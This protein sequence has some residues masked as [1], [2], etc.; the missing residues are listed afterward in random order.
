MPP[1]SKKDIDL[2]L[3][4]LHDEEVESVVL[5]ANKRILSPGRF[6]DTE[7]GDGSIKAAVRLVEHRDL[8]IRTQFFVAFGKSW[9]KLVRAAILDIKKREQRVATQRA[10]A[11]AKAKAKAK[12]QPAP[13]AQA[14]AIASP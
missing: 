11:R 2:L 4:P 6:R 8:K 12:A 5:L 1:I 9:P 10:R 14:Q 13:K 7:P 3:K